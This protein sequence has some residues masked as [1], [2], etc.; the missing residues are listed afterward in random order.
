MNV[1][2][3][4]WI[5]ELFFTFLIDL[6]YEIEVF[7]LIRFFDWIDHLALLAEYLGSENLWWHGLWLVFVPTCVLCEVWGRLHLWYH[8]Y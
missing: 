1:S 7:L 2:G 5:V 3:S 6:L 8:E 4:G